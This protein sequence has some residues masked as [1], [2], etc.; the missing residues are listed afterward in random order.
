MGLLIMLSSASYQSKTTQISESKRAHPKVNTMI[1]DID[2][3]AKPTLSNPHS[4]S[5]FGVLSKVGNN[6][7]KIKKTSLAELKKILKSNKTDSVVETSKSTDKHASVITQ[8]TGVSNLATLDDIFHKKPEK[9]ETEP[10]KSPRTKK[11]KARG[12]N[13]S[14]LSNEFSEEAEEPSASSTEEEVYLEEHN[15][16][17]SEETSEESPTTSESESEE[18]PFH[19]QD[20]EKVSELIMK[21]KEDIKSEILGDLQ[22]EMMI[23]KLEVSFEVYEAINEVRKK[24]F[25][26]KDSIEQTVQLLKDMVDYL[27]Q[28]VTDSTEDEAIQEAL[29]KKGIEVD[30]HNH[31]LLLGLLIKLQELV[32]KFHDEIFSTFNDYF[33]ELNNI[34]FND[35]IS[36]SEK[37]RKMIQIASE[38]SIFENNVVDDMS[39]QIMEVARLSLDNPRYDHL[40]KAF[41]R[42]F[43]PPGQGVNEGKL[44]REASVTLVKTVVMT[45]MLFVALR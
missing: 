13:D 33:K 27:E 45:C 43:I 8:S 21:I 3:L 23:K 4:T 7:Q 37:V 28:F 30:E 14:E 36:D 16:K 11:S 15:I 1:D 44:S 29:A 39:S 20:L 17:D 26:F 19:I 12:L 42:E 6:P 24:Y 32:N 25:Y 34:H 18:S 22:N 5:E 10:K 2:K 38:L 9:A 41:E 31:K 35:D 40:S